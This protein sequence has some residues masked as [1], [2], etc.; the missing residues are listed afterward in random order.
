V[1]NKREGY[2][3]ELW[4]EHGKTTIRTAIYLHLNDLSE[5]R[6]ATSHGRR[7][8]GYYKITYR[9]RRILNAIDKSKTLL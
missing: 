7:G 5:R 8:R 3:N 6:L 2:G 4:M 9:R 1:L